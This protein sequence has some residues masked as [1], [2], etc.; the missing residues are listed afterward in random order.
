[1]DRNGCQKADELD[2]VGWVI[3]SR[4]VQGLPDHVEDPLVLA[5]V[6]KLLYGDDATDKKT[7]QWHSP[8]PA[9]AA[10]QLLLPEQRQNMS[11]SHRTDERQLCLPR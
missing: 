8:A 7:K 2:I 9:S 5:Q 10:V 11:E 6:V 4:R 3:R 1:M